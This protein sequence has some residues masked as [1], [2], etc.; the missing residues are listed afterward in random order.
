MRLLPL[1]L[2]AAGLTGC[3]GSDPVA[4]PESDPTPSA[5]TYSEQVRGTFLD[6][7]LDNAKNTASGAVSEEQ[8]RTTCECILGKVEQEYSEAEFAR[9]EQRLL[10]GG[11]S[12]QES[13]QLT[14][15]STDCA[16]EAAS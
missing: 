6:A 15:W 14:T 7:C 1:L 8:L 2:L 13:G 9:F 16:R 3:G 10:G 5:S 12:A 11:A 4:A